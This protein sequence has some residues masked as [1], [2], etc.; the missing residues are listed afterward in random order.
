MGVAGGDV[1]AVV[2]EAVA[3]ADAAAGI[4]APS[5][6]AAAALEGDGVVVDSVVLRRH[7]VG[8]A[9]GL[10]DDAIGAA[11]DHDRVTVDVGVAAG[12]DVDGGTLHRHAG[13]GTITCD[14]VAG[15]G[16]TVRGLPV[17]AVVGIIGNGVAADGDI[18]R[19]DVEP[20]AVAPIVMNVVVE[21]LDVRAGG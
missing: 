11:G 20:D 21:D 6:H 12:G 4:G 16:G 7:L 8:T 18:G 14:G 3:G 5:V 19:M 9:D 13:A 17:D 15:D 1:V 10:H 2:I